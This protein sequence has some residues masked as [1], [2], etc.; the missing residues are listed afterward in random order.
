[1]PHGVAAGQLPRL[2]P[3]ARPGRGWQRA[4][5]P[6]DK[7]QKAPENRLLALALAKDVRRRCRAAAA[8][9]V[10]SAAI[11]PGSL[12]G[13]ALS[14]RVQVLPAAKTPRRRN[15]LNRRATRRSARLQM[16]NVI[17]AHR[18]RPWSA[19]TRAARK[20]ASRRR[21]NALQDGADFSPGG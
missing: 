16:K 17:L 18:S 15:K 4:S 14:W 9:A 10:N 7:Q 2:P 8:T 5:T 11:R 6:Q 12:V 20:P 3:P 21:Y 19:R 1:M 13:V